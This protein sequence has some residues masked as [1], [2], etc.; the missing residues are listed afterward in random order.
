VFVVKK[1]FVVY[2]CKPNIICV[3]CCESWHYMT[4]QCFDIDTVGWVIWPVKTR[5]RYDLYVF[6]GTLSLTQ[7][8]NHISGSVD[9]PLLPYTRVTI[10]SF[11]NKWNINRCKYSI[12]KYTRF[13]WFFCN[14]IWGVF[15]TGLFA[16]QIPHHRV[17]STHAVQRHTDTF[18]SWKQVEIKNRDA[19]QQ[20]SAKNW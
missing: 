5:P 6:G 8:I 19:E 18:R 14:K 7:S 12:S 20:E 4:L 15:F 3:M 2:N 1:H 17:P 16:S 10:C 11:L 9:F 13:L